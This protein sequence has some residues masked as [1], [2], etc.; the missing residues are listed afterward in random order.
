MRKGALWDAAWCSAWGNRRLHT[1]HVPK[2]GIV[3]H[4][5]TQYGDCRPLR[6]GDPRKILETRK[7]KL[8]DPREPVFDQMAPLC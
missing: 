6:A 7:R 4:A 2:C 8:I 5:L 3:L 1:V